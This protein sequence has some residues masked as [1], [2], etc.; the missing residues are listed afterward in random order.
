MKNT[1]G[2]LNHLK[3]I[4]MFVIMLF[5]IL[6]YVCHSNGLFPVEYLNFIINCRFFHLFVLSYLQT[7]LLTIHLFLST[8]IISIYFR[9][10]LSLPQL[11][12]FVFNNKLHHVYLHSSNYTNDKNTLK[13]P[14]TQTTK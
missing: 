6:T 10:T 2:V 13:I 12:Y 1:P 4:I 11:H 7:T 9:F 3:G 5:V 14:L 8:Y